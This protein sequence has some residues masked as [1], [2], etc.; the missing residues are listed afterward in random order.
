MEQITNFIESI[1]ALQI[2]D[3]LIAVAIILVFRILSS[4]FSY[5]II[6]MFK[7]KSKKSIFLKCFIFNCRIF[8]SFE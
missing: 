8:I 6:R 7:F 4:T 2:I 1:K 3:I 5:M